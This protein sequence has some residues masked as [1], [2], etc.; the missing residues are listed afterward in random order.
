MAGVD[1]MRDDE[2]DNTPP[3]RDTPLKKKGNFKQKKSIPKTQ[4]LRNGFFHYSIKEIYP[5]FS[6]ER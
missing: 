1:E 5:K 2:K 4:C 6:A 3:L